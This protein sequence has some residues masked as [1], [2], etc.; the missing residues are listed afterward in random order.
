MAR[1]RLRGGTVHQPELRSAARGG[2]DGSVDDL[3]AGNGH[4]GEG[5]AVRGAVERH[6]GGAGDGG[7]A[8]EVAG[9]ERERVRVEG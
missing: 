7:A 5:G 4:V 1:V 8:D 2:F 6:A 3:R 9:I